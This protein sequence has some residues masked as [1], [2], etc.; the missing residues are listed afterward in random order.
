MAAPMLVVLTNAAAALLIALGAWTVSRIVRRPALVHGLWLLALVKLVAPPLVPLP[1]L[2]DWR[3]R[4]PGAAPDRPV[5]VRIERP[6]PAEASSRRLPRPAAPSAEPSASLVPGI[7]FSALADSPAPAPLPE[8]SVDP[9]L[10]VAL[11]FAAGALGVG[12]LAGLRFLRF[13]RLLQC[14][15][16]ASP[17]LSSRVDA[18]ALK[19]GVRRA[20]PLKLVPARV[21]PMLWP[22]G[23]GPELLF[24]EGLLPEVSDDER[25]ALLAHELAHVRRR[26]HWV[27]L[28]ELV[29]T[30]LFWWYPVAWWV[31]ASL[32]RVEERCCDEWVLRV[33]PGSSRAYANGLLKS[34]SFVAGDSCAL[35]ALASGAGPVSDLEARLKEILMTRPVPRLA[36][37]VRLAL[38]TAATLGLAV[39]PTRAQERAH[40]DEAPTVATAEK[41]SPLPAV[42][43]A[44]PATPAIPDAAPA[45]ASAPRPA[46]AVAASPAPPRPVS[47]APVMAAVE[48]PPAPPAKPVAPETPAASRRALE[49]ALRSLEAQRV[50][51][52]KEQLELERQQV[53]IE[54]QVQQEALRKEAARLRSRGEAERAALVEQ[55]AEVAARRAE[56][57]RRHL[58]LEG[59]RMALEAR[60][61]ATARAKAERTAARDVEQEARRLEQLSAEEQVRALRE[62]TREISSSLAA[63]IEALRKSLDRLGPQRSE[64]EPEMLRLEKALSALREN[65][66]P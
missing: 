46:V 19:I 42:A 11:V 7:G 59:E 65:A 66:R 57:E 51:L 54:T 52:R 28:V 64:L 14:A 18:L 27:R 31:R 13:R 45:P 50:G 21:P 4:L 60:L 40:A 58:E 15:S 55:Q 6:E 39:F 43:P 16:P 36:A 37:S 61:E 17:A 12:G 53:E 29:A 38:A 56:I 2:P 30:S 23:G 34:L 48:I 20:P 62:A 1:L 10:V 25:D 26:D 63:Q 8:I 33:L 3:M 49:E 24:P 41:A 44:P 9:T 5:L 32:R 22:T 47:A 35:P